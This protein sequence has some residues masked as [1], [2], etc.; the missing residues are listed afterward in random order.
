MSE[1]PKDLFYTPEHEYLRKTDEDGVYQVG[2]T[3]Y[4]QGASFERMQPFGTIEAVKAVS[5]LYC[6]ATGQ[7]IEINKDL[8][9]D[10]ELVNSDPYG[11]GWMIKL[12][13]ADKA[14]LKS[15]LDAAGYAALVGGT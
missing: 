15:L 9:N 3:D 1:I 13:V 14:D 2:V 5:D 7:V 11:K 8:A 6:P 4:A 10:P 12:K